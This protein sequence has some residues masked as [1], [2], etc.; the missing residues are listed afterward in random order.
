MEFVVTAL[1]DTI[2]LREAHAIHAMLVTHHAGS[3]V[4]HRCDK[5]EAV[6]LAKIIEDAAT[7]RAFPLRVTAEEL[8]S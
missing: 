7:A 6:R 3:A 5:D 2:M 1:R 4:I 8:R